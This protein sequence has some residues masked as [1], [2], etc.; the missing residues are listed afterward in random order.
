MPCFQDITK[1]GE[2]LAWL[3]STPHKNS[4]GNDDDIV[5]DGVV[6]DKTLWGK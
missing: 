4:G 1:Y 2:M 5:V 6:D 3:E